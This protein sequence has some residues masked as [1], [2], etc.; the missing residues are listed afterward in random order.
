MKH[1]TYVIFILVLPFLLNLTSCEYDSDSFHY[2]GIQPPKAPEIGINL[3]DVSSEGTIYIYTKT[4]LYYSL[5]TSGKELLAQNFTFEG[6]NINKIGDYIYLAPQ[7]GEEKKYKLE[8]DIA[9]KSNSGSIADIVGVE[10]LVGKYVYYVQFI[11]S[12][13]K[14]DLKQDVTKD[15]YFR[16]VWNNPKLEQTE[17]D[18]Y[19][20]HFEDITGLSHSITISDPDQTYY[21]DESYAYGYRMYTVETYFKD[22]RIASWSD[23]YT[24]QYRSLSQTDFWISEY[25]NRNIQISW[26]PNDFKCKYY[27]VFPDNEP[28]NHYRNS[29]T[30]YLYRPPFPVVNMPANVYILPET[31]Q[32][33]DYQ[34]VSPVKVNISSNKFNT[35][36]YGYAASKDDDLIFGYAANS[37]IALDSKLNWIGSKGVSGITS[38][39][40]I[41]VA[42]STLISPYTKVATHDD[43]GK[44]YILGYNKDNKKWLDESISI[45]IP[46]TNS[47]YSL[48][49]LTTNDRLFISNT[50]LNNH[51]CNVYNS[52]TGEIIH[53][54]IP[55][56]NINSSV[57]VST[58]GKYMC[59]VTPQKIILYEYFVDNNGVPQYFKADAWNNLN[60]Y[61]GCKFNPN[62]SSQLILTSNSAFCV[63][64]LYPTAF[65]TPIAG[66]FIDFDPFTGYLLYSDANHIGNHL[67]YVMGSANQGNIWQMEI[68]PLYINKDIYLY[69]SNLI[70]DSYYTNI[71]ALY[72]Q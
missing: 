32:Y 51:Y 55:L 61:T 62:N 8:V 65:G 45:D 31:V 36:N 63:L 69:N 35:I 70:I 47:K 1:L 34:K 68:N 9:L 41:S 14:L 7:S 27:V 2:E 49:A 67:I 13:L 6:G 23:N 17:V 4:K 33:S 54:D 66:H 60:Q 24:A 57:T 25:D 29:S 12:D 11:N 16:L 28:V 18:H 64:K 43:S 22:E 26:I 40:S 30:A 46:K 42:P 53:K 19:V 48:F 37:L 3:A 50:H 15:K 38:F 58:N 10:S 20:V 39:S 56:N 52:L 72:W 5:N 21:V 59:E 71:E 44:A